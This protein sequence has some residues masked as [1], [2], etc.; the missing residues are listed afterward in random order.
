MTVTRVVSAK[1]HFHH[2]IDEKEAEIDR[3]LLNMENSNPPYHYPGEMFKILRKT[4]LASI[5][6]DFNMIIEEYGF[7][8]KLTT[9]D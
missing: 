3:W 5:T 6:N 1:Y 8:D 7:W 4:A 9:K 2:Y